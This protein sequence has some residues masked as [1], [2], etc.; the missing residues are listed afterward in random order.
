MRQQIVV[1]EVEEVVTATVDDFLTHVNGS[2]LRADIIRQV[3]LQ[4]DFD[5]LLEVLADNQKMNVQSYFVRSIKRQVTASL[6][7]RRDDNGLRQYPAIRIPGHRER[8]WCEFQRMT[9]DQVK[10][11]VGSKRQTI[12]ETQKQHRIYTQIALA[13]EVAGPNARVADVYD[14]VVNAEA[15]SGAHGQGQKR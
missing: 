2:F 4:P 8:L 13:L 12:R 6:Q 1:P 7:R 14:L 5:E 9:V 15:G 3:L 11:L 10:L